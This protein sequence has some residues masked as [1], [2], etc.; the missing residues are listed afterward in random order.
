MNFT[1]A[2]LAL[3]L[4]LIALGSISGARSDELVQVA[5]HRSAAGP[6]SSDS[7]PPLLG[8]LARP[9][10]PGRFPAVVLLHGCIGFD[11]HD[12]AAASM[13]KA[14][15]Y[16]ALALDS[17]GDANTCRDRESGG[18][19]AEAFDAYSGLRYLAARTFVASGRV[20][21]MGYSAGG[22]AALAAVDQ[23][24]IVRA[25]RGSFR[26]MIAYYPA[27]EFS[28]GML[29]APALILIG[30]KD[31]WSPADACRKLAAHKSDIG[32]T[33]DGASGTPLDL[34]VYPDTT[35]AFDYPVPTQRYLGYLIQYNEAAAADAEAQVRA[36]LRRVLGDQPEPG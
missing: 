35:H 33:R 27:C 15:G 11:G 2:R 34:V 36:F 17:M 24:W 3:L 30:E 26:A 13:L 29:T 20:A 14:W 31:D 8:F 19:R 1:L 28:T 22:T 21:V 9:T 23:K 10:G 7:T 6:R 12:T 18:V 16:V 25:E 5:S 32:I 4:T